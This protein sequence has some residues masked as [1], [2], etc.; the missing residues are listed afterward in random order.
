MTRRHI[1]KS[2]PEKIG[3]TLIYIVLLLLFFISLYPLW[4]TLMYSISDSG[5]ALSGGYFLLPK[6]FSL[7]AFKI[8][9]RT[10]NLYRAMINSFVRMGLGT[11]VDVI[12]TC[13]MAYALASEAFLIRKAVTLMIFVTMIFS[14]GMIPGYLTLKAYGLI[15]TFWALVLPGAIDPFYMFMMRTYFQSLP[16][17]LEESA[18]IDGATPL[19]ILRSIIMPISLPTIAAISVMYAVG[20]WN[21]YFDAMLY[22]NDTSKIVLQQYLKNMQEWFV[23]TG[24]S[25]VSQASVKMATIVVS[26]IPPILLYPYVQKYYVTGLMVGAIKG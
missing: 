16:R 26:L 3:L 12:M 21:A 17:E 25:E 1:K 18:K 19:R 7:R 5:L 4:Y 22:I 8:V 9:L 2:I 23:E 6:G 15:N 20:H 13:L 11:T 14:G 10:K 24:S